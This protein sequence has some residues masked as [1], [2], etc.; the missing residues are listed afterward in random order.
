DRGTVAESIP[1]RIVGAVDGTTL[2]YDPPIPNAATTLQSGQ[3]IEF[4]TVGAFTVRSQDADH[5]FYVGQ[6]MPGCNV[7]GNSGNLGDEE[8]VN[9][10]PPAQFLKKYVFFTDPTYPTTNLVFIRVADANGTF[11]DV[12]LDCLGAVSGWQ[13]VGGSGRYEITNV[14]L[15]RQGVSNGGC[16]NGPHVAESEGAFGLMVWGLDWFSSYGYPAGGSVAQINTVTVPPV[17]Q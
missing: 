14:D 6:I 7:T 13:A 17:P 15:I 9:I 3:V 10:L 4:E 2:T 1:Y 11:Y 5:P 12:N 16:T 8:Y